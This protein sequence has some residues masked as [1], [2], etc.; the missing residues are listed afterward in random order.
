MIP[1][2]FNVFAFLVE[3]EFDDVEWSHRNNGIILL[4]M[5]KFSECRSFQA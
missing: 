2:K 3:Y 4:N 5:L 1:Y